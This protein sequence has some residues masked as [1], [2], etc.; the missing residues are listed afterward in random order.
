MRH[1][2]RILIFI[3]AVNNLMSQ[4]NSSYVQY[5]FNGLLLNPAY[6]GSQE[7]LNLTAIY[8][9]QWSGIPG[10]P[11]NLSFGAHTPLKNDHLNVGLV[12]END[13]FGISEHT[14]AGLIYA[15]RLK[16]SKGRLS[17]G[18]KGGV[19]IYNASRSRLN[20]RDPDDPNFTADYVNVAD[21][22]A[23]AGLY[24]YSDNFYI[25]YAAA[26]LLDQWYN[27]RLMTLNSGCVLDFSDEIKV[28][29]SFILKYLYN[30][31]LSVNLSNVLY[32]K[33]FLGLG[34][35]Y[36]YR[37]SLQ[38]FADLRLNEQFY[39]GYGYEY[40]LSRIRHYATGSHEVMLRYLFRYKINA[41]NAR[42][43]N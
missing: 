29:P 21:P 7:A 34:L 14:R 1:Y 8:R 9:N 33:N 38:V 24:Y 10:A 11:V 3:L 12:L 25:G 20:M 30:S 36:T 18:L 32:Y 16:L 15:H 39:F 19:D 42:Y 31:P 17:F 41:S 35:G 22:D 13:K 28:K 2:I 6:A 23:S 37:S 43:F 40:A 4:H 5:M 26:G 27:Y